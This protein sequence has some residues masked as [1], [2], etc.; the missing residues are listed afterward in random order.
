MSKLL[1]N[2]SQNAAAALTNI[3]NNCCIRQHRFDHVT[4]VDKVHDYHRRLFL[5]AWHSQ[6]DQNAGNE[7]IEISDIINFVVSR[8]SYSQR[9]SVK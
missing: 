2:N 7:H 3:A 6:R 8:D 9:L 1:P 5:E 4:I